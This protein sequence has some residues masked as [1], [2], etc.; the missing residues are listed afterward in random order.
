[1]N[2]ITF[3]IVLVAAYVFVV[4]YA[5]A[6]GKRKKRQNEEPPQKKETPIG[7]DIGETENK[8]YRAGSDIDELTSLLFQMPRTRAL[9]A[10]KRG[11]D[12]PQLSRD[13]VGKKCD[14]C[15]HYTVGNYVDGVWEDSLVNEFIRK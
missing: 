9:Q 5:R 3:G 1:M 8:R 14:D 12:C 7:K 10:R 11:F 4:L 6:I 15:E 2:L 13:C